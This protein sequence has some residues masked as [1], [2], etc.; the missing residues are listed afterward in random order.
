VAATERAAGAF[1]HW[2]E[3]ALGRRDERVRV[4]TRAQPSVVLDS[5]CH[6]CTAP[7]CTT[8]VFPASPPVTASNLDYLRFALGFPGV[9]V[10]VTGDEWQLAVTSSCRHHVGGRCAAYGTSERPIRCEY[11]DAWQC[12]PRA[13]FDV[14]P[15]PAATR[16][17]LEEFPA[18]LS[19]FAFD[20]G[21]VSVAVPDADAVRAAIEH[22]WRTAG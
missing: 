3:V 18:V 20:D 14:V 7:C 11:L 9:E 1:E 2:R 12:R 8:L 21:G 10:V 19:C 6:D 15:S 22:A 17:R 5:P 16:I 4:P 13:T